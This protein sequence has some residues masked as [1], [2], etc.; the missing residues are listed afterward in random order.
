MALKKKATKKIKPD[1]RK[2][3]ETKIKKK[4][5]DNSIVN[6]VVRDMED[7]FVNKDNKYC[8]I[9]EEYV[10]FNN[11]EKT[12]SKLFK[13]GRIHICNDCIGKLSLEYYDIYKDIKDVLMILCS[14]TNTLVI[15][16]CLDEAIKTV[17]VHKSRRK[18]MFSIYSDLLDKYISDN[19]TWYKSSLSFEGSNFSGKPFNKCCI[20]ESLTRIYEYESVD[21]LDEEYED[22]DIELTPQLRKRLVKKWGDKDDEDLIWLDEREKSYYMTHNIPNDHINKSAV[23]TL[24]NLELQEFKTLCEGGDVKKILESKSRVLSTT[25]FSPKK[26]AKEGNATNSLSLSHLIKI[27]EDYSPIIN[28]D[29]DLDD[30]DKLSTIGKSLAGALCRTAKIDSPLIEEFDKAMK[31]YTFEFSAGDN[32]E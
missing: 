10:D 28:S 1:V 8:I 3:V 20:D 13:D 14:I 2:E 27:R 21:N 31:D 15:K 16:E 22:E 18:D 5:E 30:I 24:C 19:G 25:S 12:R 17:N 7:L 29:P 11:F 9:C 6:G 4:A 23:I 32:D 26:K